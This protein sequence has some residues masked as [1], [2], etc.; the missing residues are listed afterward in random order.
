MLSKIKE[1][2]E[3]AL[4]LAPSERALLAE[5]LINSLDDMEDPEAER[6]WIEEAERRY[7]AYKEGKIKTKRAELVFQDVRLKL[8]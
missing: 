4:Q 5:H 3:E 8:G 2:E 7:L 6:L 1:I